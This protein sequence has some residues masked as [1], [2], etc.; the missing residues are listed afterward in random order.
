MPSSTSLLLVR[1]VWHE[2]ADLARIA[3]AYD[4]APFWSYD[5]PGGGLL[6]ANGTGVML[7]AMDEIPS[8]SWCVDVTGLRWGETLDRWLEFAVWVRRLTTH[9]T[10][11][12]VCYIDD[13]APLRALL[14][15]FEVDKLAV[16][17]NRPLHPSAQCEWQGFVDRARRVALVTGR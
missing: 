10:A 14:E 3:A 2:R 9:V 13:P 6:L 17:G 11:T 16:Y 1:S 12:L 7:S 15:V 5:R 4:I 8:L